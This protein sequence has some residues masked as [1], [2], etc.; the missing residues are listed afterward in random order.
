MSIPFPSPTIPAD[1]RAEVFLGYLGY[2]RE[3]LLSK[4]E[5]LPDDEVRR[6]RLPSGWTPIELVKHLTHVE[7]RW[8]VWG[9][10]GQDVSDPWADHRDGRWFV[11]PDQPLGEVAQELRTQAATTNRVVRAH[12]LTDVGQPGERWDGAEPAPLE[13]VL[14]H[15]LQEY[16]RHAGHID[17]V[18]EMVDGRVG[19]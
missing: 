7:R 16:A 5:D 4:V 13:R 18:R 2:F 11:P 10:E 9:F 3:V 19:E 12:D 8:V 17:I 1:S 14:F 15:L 6:S